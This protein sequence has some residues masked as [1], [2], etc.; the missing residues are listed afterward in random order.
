MMALDE[1]ALIC[2]F[3]ET[4]GIYDI[5]QFP[6]EYIATLAIGLRINS[7][8][9]MKAYGLEMDINSLLLAHI[10]DNTAINVW[11]K[12]EDAR[13]NK[14]R[15]KSFVKIMNEKIDMSKKP[16][17]FRSGEDFDKTWERM[18]NGC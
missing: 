7:R 9:K 15:P 14:N 12:T 16:K 5:Y 11:T 17:Q 2:D 10:A 4:Y 6:V 8:I 3:A 18:I 1:D 13:K